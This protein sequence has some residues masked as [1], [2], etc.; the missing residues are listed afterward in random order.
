MDWIVNLSI[1]M[2][3]I[4]VGICILITGLILFLGPERSLIEF[5]KTIHKTKRKMENEIQSERQNSRNRRR[6]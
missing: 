2:I 4:I 5:L 1:G 6:K 3:L